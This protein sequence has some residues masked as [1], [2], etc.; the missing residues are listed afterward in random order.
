MAGAII[1]WLR[2]GLGLIERASDVEQLTESV[3]YDQSEVMVPGFTGLGAPCWDPTA[4][5]AI[6]GMTRDTGAKQLVAAAIPSVALQSAGLLRALARDG[7]EVNTP[8]VDGGV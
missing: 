1:Q 6:F 3:P 7:V 2:D 4:R 8:P 5:A